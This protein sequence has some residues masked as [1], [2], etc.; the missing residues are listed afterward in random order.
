MIVQT[1]FLRYLIQ[2]LC[3]D[4]SACDVIDRSTRLTADD[5]FVCQQT[6]TGANVMIELRHLV[7]YRTH[8]S[9]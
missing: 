4:I 8:F 9:V 6:A 1:Q 3:L 2:E 7:F 5:Q